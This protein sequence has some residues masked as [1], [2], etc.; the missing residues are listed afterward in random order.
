MDCVTCLHHK[1]AAVSLVLR[2]NGGFL[3]ASPGAQAANPCYYISPVLSPWGRLRKPMG[4]GSLSARQLGDC[5]T[6]PSL[7]SPD[8]S[9][10]S[11]LPP[12][13]VPGSWS[14]AWAGSG[15]RWMLPDSN[16]PSGKFTRMR[17]KHTVC[18]THSRCAAS[19]AP[20]APV[21]HAHTLLC[22]CLP[23]S[24]FRPENSPKQ[25]SFPSVP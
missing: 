8:S 21:L 12:A 6:C 7:F 10:L 14:S 15:K 13:L 19:A 18:L 2:S 16:Q 11:W 4:K 17:G 3:G 22:S 20:T 9:R 25:S 24:F 23:S 1:T 5:S